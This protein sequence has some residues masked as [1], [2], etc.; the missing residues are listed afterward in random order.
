MKMRFF[1]AGVLALLCV[2]GCTEQKR[3]AVE[4]TDEADSLTTDSLPADTIADIVEDAPLPKAVDELFDDFFFNFAGN[5]HMQMSRIDFPLPIHEDG[6]TK[7]LDR[8]QWR[9]SHFFMSDGYYTLLL[10]HEEQESLSKDSQ[11]DHAEVEKLY[12]NENLVKHYVFNR[13]KGEWRLTS[14][15]H[16]RLSDHPCGQFLHFYQHFATDTAFQAQSLGEFVLMTA[17]DSDEELSDVTGAITREQWPFFK[18]ALIPDNIIYNVNYGQTLD[19][20]KQKVMMVRGVANGLSISMTFKRK[21]EQWRLVS[22]S[23]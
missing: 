9:Y 8:K 15:A 16:T 3:V 23:E 5:R 7:M 21:N 22:F 4:E 12:M 1:V 19:D 13:I 11:L 2:A 14:V 10:D 20:D 6:E 17:S 18:P